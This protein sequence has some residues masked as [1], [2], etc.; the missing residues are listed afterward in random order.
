MNL[1]TMIYKYKEFHPEKMNLEYL[2][3][4][5]NQQVEF[6]ATVNNYTDILSMCVSIDIHL[7]NITY[8]NEDIFKMIE[9][10]N[11]ILLKFINKICFF[12]FDV[13]CLFS[14][15]NQVLTSFEKKQLF[16]FYSYYEKEDFLILL[17]KEKKI[18]QNISYDKIY[19]T[20]NDINNYFFKPQ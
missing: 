2:D 9:I 15:E 18:E 7:N 17:G 12:N 11:Q 20:I 10:E 6:N 3:E 8:S 13:F 4:F 1:Q 14:L 19:S 16:D 5:L